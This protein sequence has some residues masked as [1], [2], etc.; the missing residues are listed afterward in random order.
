VRERVPL[1]GG[2]WDFG[3]RAGV[4]ALDLGR[5]RGHSDLRLGFRPAFVI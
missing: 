3:S 1:R 2:N 4:F 5:D